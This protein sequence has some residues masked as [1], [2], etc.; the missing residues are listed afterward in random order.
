MSRLVLERA[1]RKT[2]LGATQSRAT[3]DTAKENCAKLRLPV[4]KS[5]FRERRLSHLEGRNHSFG[6]A[7]DAPP[8]NAGT[9]PNAHHLGMS[10]MPN[11][12]HPG[13]PEQMPNAN[14]PETS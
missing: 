11:S 1:P 8:G 5:Q 10:K 6:Y 12:N 9:M 3:G 2:G 14:H 7:T 13:V 4:N